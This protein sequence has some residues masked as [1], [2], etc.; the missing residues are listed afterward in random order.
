MVFMETVQL[1]TKT[2][3]LEEKKALKSYSK[4][5]LLTTRQGRIAKQT[6]TKPK[7]AC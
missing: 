5:T 2:Y 7:H 6:Q 1:K 4:Q 3:K